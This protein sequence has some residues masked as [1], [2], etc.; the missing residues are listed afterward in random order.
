MNNYLLI[1]IL[2]PLTVLDTVNTMVML[3]PSEEGQ[4]V[5]KNQVP[6]GQRWEDDR[7]DGL[8]E[9]GGHGWIREALPK[10]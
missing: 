7:L 8:R 10:Q 4:A 6:C 2:L 1:F 9:A 5:N 3:L